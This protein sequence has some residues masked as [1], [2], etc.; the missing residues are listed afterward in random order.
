VELSLE[1]VTLAVE[2]AAR[3]VNG[4]ATVRRLYL[5]EYQAADAEGRGFVEK[6]HLD[7]AEFLRVLHR[8]ADRDGDGKLSAAELRAFLDLHAS[9]AAALV[10]AALID[11]SRGVFDLLDA[12][13]NGRLSLRELKGAWDRLKGFDRNGDGVLS[14]AEL[15]RTYRVRFSQG[16]MHPGRSVEKPL[17]PLAE[18]KQGPA[19]FRNMDRNGDGDVSLREFIGPIEL[20]RKLDRDGDGLIS[21]EEAE[22][23]QFPDRPANRR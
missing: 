14:R 6:K 7:D 17:A 23:A 2:V 1:T 10:S 19:W 18:K 5:Q 13:G 3:P 12:D 11:E 4:F 22:Q 21:K 16:H 9:G 20:F 15:P 8:L